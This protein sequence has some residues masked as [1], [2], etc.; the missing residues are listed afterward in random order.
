[1]GFLSRMEK[2]TSIEDPKIPLSSPEAFSIIFGDYFK[3]ATGI[4]V[5]VER[6]LSVPAFW[7]GTNFISGTIASLPLVVYKENEKG[8][9]DAA[10]TD[11]L[12]ALLHDV[13]NA[14][15]L[16]SYKWRKQAMMSVLTQG[17][18]FTYIER[19]KAMR[20]ANLWPLDPKTVTVKRANHQTKYEVKEGAS[21]VTHTYDASEII[22]IP[23]TLLPDCIS[24]YSPIATL[25]NALGLAI[26]MEEYACRFFQGGGIPPLSLEGPPASPGAVR[27]AT[28][29]IDEAVRE[30][31]DE[32]RNVLYLPTGHKLTPI[33]FKPAEGQLKEVRLFQLQEIARILSLPPV[34]LQDLS[35]GTYTNSEQQDLHYVK[36]TLTQWLELWE[37]ELNAKLFAGTR[38][39]T[40]FAEFKV[41]AL[42]RGDFAS[43][44]EG[45]S[46]AIQNGVM[47][48]DEARDLENRP[49]KGG[50][51][52]E[53][54]VNSTI[55]PITKQ[56]DLPL[57][58]PQG[59]KPNGGP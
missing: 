35:N 10:R 52:N 30:A 15:K 4:N 50:A 23:F 53:L 13:V 34:F 27:R 1:M 31:Y 55:V 54:F 51:A 8:R 36:H 56:M 3:S 24:H 48:P 16:T 5:T 17:R 46:K 40:R 57:N 6:A 11:P 32:N 44:M 28:T 9:L 38:A 58:D 29:Q 2:R 12:Y 43:R 7:G 41:D 21:G 47:T 18:A 20:V 33:G 37:Q 49:A 39:A 26:A 14:D 59:G 45:Y 25:K 42:L 22:D 19:N